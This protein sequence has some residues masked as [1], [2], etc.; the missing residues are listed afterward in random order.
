MPRKKTTKTVETP[1][2]MPAETVAEAVVEAA[3]EAP[4]EEKKAPVKRA[5]CKKS[6]VYVQYAGKEVDVNAVVEAAKAAF[7]GKKSDI[8]S[9]SVY[10]KP[11]EEK[12]Y[13][14]INDTETGSVDL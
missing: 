5:A 4:A 6:A 10:V 12:A 8:K 1:E 14:V 9:V 2:V 3:A 7:P 11:E 13:Y